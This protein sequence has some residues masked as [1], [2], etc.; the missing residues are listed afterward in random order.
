[1]R[2]SSL[3]FVICATLAYAQSPAEQHREPS[4]ASIPPLTSSSQSDAVSV[5]ES[6]A[7]A[8]S[9]N[10]IQGSV[11]IQGPYRGSV[12]TGTASGGVLSLTLSEAVADGLKSN[13]GAVTQ[14]LAVRQAEGQRIDARSLLLPH[15]SSI[16]TETVQ[17]L[18]LR[19]AGVL[20]PSFPL[21]VGPYNFFDARAARVE[22]QVFDPVSLGNLRAAG[23]NVQSTKDAALDSRDIIVLAVAGSYLRIVSMEAGILAAHAQVDT[24]Q[25]IFQQATDRFHAGLAARID[26]TRTE[27]QLDNDRQ[28]LRALEADLEKAKLDLARLIGL[29]H[30]QRL[31]ISDHFPYTPLGNYTLDQLL[32]DAES[33]R[34][35]LQAA[36]ASEKSAEFALHAAHAERL[37]NLSFQADYGAAG[38]RPT[39]EAHGVFTV[40]G[41]LSIPL[42][43]GGRVH[44]DIEQADAALQARRAALEDIRGRIDDD[45]RRSWIDANAAQ[46]QVAIAQR[47]IDLAH[48]TLTQARDRFAEGVADTV[49]VV[50]AQQT[51][52]QAENDYIN[53]IFA[54]NLAKVSLARAEGD[55]E[56][57]LPQF[58][59]K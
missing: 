41:V 36:I 54:H 13:L 33:H 44:G 30:G 46:D 26:A 51:V 17:Q 39:A 37:P 49:E 40:A 31:E 6:A 32:A 59:R 28:R 8:Q 14:S 38:L 21:A 53:A 43:Q 4:R 12:A 55:T 56:R 29:P 23:Q 20:E 16:V 45:V 11:S 22:Q 34:S 3:L 10:G 47:N 25:A 9:G 50:Q 15:V 2:H 57:R 52:T 35:D 27:V 7:G 5:T 58:L 1:M 42:Y 48:D 19:T 18:N 24:S